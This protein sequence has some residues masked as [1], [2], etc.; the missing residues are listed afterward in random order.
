MLYEHEQGRGVTAIQ[1][2]LNGL[3]TSAKVV[4]EVMILVFSGD[5]E[6]AGNGRGPFSPIRDLRSDK[7]TVEDLPIRVNSWST[8]SIPWACRVLSFDETL[9]EA[10]RYVND[11][12]A[13]RIA[14][15]DLSM[16]FTDEGSILFLCA[17]E[18][19]IK[20]PADLH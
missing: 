18:V 17:K 14:L 19:V 1:F 15:R 10:Q 5:I 20:D 13:C 2:Q 16:S 3:I 8:G 12:L 11:K 6:I 7:W 4:E 9:S